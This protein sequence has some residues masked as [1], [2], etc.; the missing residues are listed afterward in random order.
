MITKVNIGLLYCFSQQN[1]HFFYLMTMLIVVS[2]VKF[3]SCLYPF[4]SLTKATGGQRKKHPLF[5]TQWYSSQNYTLFPL[6]WL[7]YVWYS[8]PVF[9]GK[10][11]ITVVT[12][13]VAYTICFDMICKTNRTFSWIYVIENTH[14]TD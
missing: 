12:F 4:G 9:D 14:L 6:D 2:D 8:P 7:Q 13:L 10:T 5:S 11:V 3:H 1:T